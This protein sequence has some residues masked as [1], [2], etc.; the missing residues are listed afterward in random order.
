MKKS[1]I[2]AAVVATA[3]A[4]SANAGWFVISSASASGSTTGT[5]P[6]AGAAM[7]PG[8]AGTLAQPGSNTLGILNTTDYSNIST[9][10]GLGSLATD[11]IHYFGMENTGSGP[12]FFGFAFRASVGVG[13][14]VNLN[15]QAGAPSGSGVLVG[16]GDGTTSYGSY[17]TVSGQFS[18]SAPVVVNSGDTLIVLFANLSAGSAVSGSISLDSGAASMGINYLSFNGSNYASI[19]GVTGATASQLNIATYAVPVP[20]PALLAGAGLVGAAALRRRMAKKA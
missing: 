2:A 13:L 14:N 8:S 19:G 7:T 6:G 3:F 17:S 15:N 10:I 9:A 12:A 1:M 18:S 11:T 5:L 20:A 4:A 16:D